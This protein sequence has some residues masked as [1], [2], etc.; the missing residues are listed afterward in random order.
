MVSCTEFIPAYS[1]LFKFLHRKEGRAGVIRFWEHLSDA[2]LG[3]LRERAA[4]R[5]LTGC[6]EWWDEVLQEEAADYRL[7]LDEDAGTFQVVM[8]H[9]P[10]KGRLLELNHLE[11]Y[12]AYC[13]HCD[14]LYRRALEPLG[15]GY[16]VDLSRCDHATCTRTV[17]VKRR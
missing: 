3:D 16:E 11:P 5:G 13:E 15:F 14:T 17:R 8:L 9:C 10:S 12:P 4:A 7:V 1:E 2:Y 6:F